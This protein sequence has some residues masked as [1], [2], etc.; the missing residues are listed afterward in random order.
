MLLVKMWMAHPFLHLQKDG[1]TL[2]AG[3]S[4][5]RR[6][7]VFVVNYVARCAYSVNSFATLSLSVVSATSIPYVRITARLLF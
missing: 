5:I 6:F 1:E 2:M 4:C 3:K 7:A